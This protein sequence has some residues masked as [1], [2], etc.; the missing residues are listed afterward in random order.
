LLRV[1]SQPGFF[2]GDQ[3]PPIVA[4]RKSFAGQRESTD[5]GEVTTA[6]ANIIGAAKKRAEVR[7]LP[8]YLI[9]YI[10]DTTYG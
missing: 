1:K 4:I 9:G 5:I 10:L 3:H 7:N 8:K 6:S 2:R